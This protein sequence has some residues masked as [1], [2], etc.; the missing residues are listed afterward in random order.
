MLA[1][2]CKHIKPVTATCVI[3]EDHFGLEEEF[4]VIQCGFWWWKSWA[5]A[6]FIPDTG[7]PSFGD[8]FWH[9]L[10]ERFTTKSAA[11]FALQKGNFPHPYPYK[12]EQVERIFNNAR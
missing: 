11:I 2:E 9:E 6:Q 8:G 3:V 4:Y 10:G 7:V 1:K 12:A 5:I